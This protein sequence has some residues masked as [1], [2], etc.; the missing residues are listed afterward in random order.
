MPVVVPSCPTWEP[1]L[2]RPSSYSRESTD[3]SAVLVL[4][5]LPGPVSEPAA[6]RQSVTRAAATY[7]EALQAPIQVSLLSVGSVQVCMPLN[8]KTGFTAGR[9]NSCFQAGQTWRQSSL[10]E[11]LLSTSVAP[12]HSP[13]DQPP[14]LVSDSKEQYLHLPA[15]KTLCFEISNPY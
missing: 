6:S 5:L 3:T 9:G 14:Q 13:A 7:T 2:P 10:E 11:S 15:H 12:W 8:S 1:S 4:N